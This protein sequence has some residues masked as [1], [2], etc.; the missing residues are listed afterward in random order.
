MNI[1]NQ[2]LKWKLC[3]AYFSII[4][5]TLILEV[6]LD[7]LCTVAKISTE[8]VVIDSENPCPSV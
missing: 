5:K 8:E 6:S 7:Q 3:R 4:E 2:N 1:V